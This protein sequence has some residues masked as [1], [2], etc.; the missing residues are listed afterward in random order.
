MG[1]IVTQATKPS[2]SKRKK[3][4]E[5]HLAVMFTAVVKHWNEHKKYHLLKNDIKI[6]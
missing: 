3:N 1:G 4:K 2:I 5:T 6:M